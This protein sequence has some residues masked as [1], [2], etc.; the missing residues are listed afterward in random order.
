VTEAEIGPCV[1]VDEQAITA[2]EEGF[3]RLANGEV[4]LP[5]ILRVDVADQ[6][7]EVDVKTAHTPGLSELCHQDRFAV[8]P[9][10][11]LGSAQRRGRHLCAG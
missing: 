7:G 2:V 6:G 11:S 9:V 10:L 5:P 1:R 4:T 3:T 8:A